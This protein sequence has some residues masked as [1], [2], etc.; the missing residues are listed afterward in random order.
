MFKKITSLNNDIVKNLIKLN[1]KKNISTFAL[2]ESEKVV[3]S[4][5]NKQIVETLFVEEKFLDQIKEYNITTYIIT[6]A[7]SKKISSLKSP[8][9]IFALVRIPTFKETNSNFLVLENLQ[10]PSNLGAIFRCALATNY[11]TIY[12]I[13]SVC[14]YLPKVT[15]GSMGYNFDLN[16]KEFKNLDEF[17]D[18]K[19]K[20]NLYLICG[21]LNG[22]NIFDYKVKTKPYG[23]VIG[24]EG[25]GISSTMQSACNDIVTIPMQNEVESLNAS[26]SASI[27]M[28]MLNN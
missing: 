20:N 10:D 3:M 7:V 6:E 1:D 15:R 25:N 14:P 18:F 17:L 16:I 19:N 27:L 21:D 24:N 13:D 2:C 8:S 9:G 28:Y 12:L 26:V 5:L 4:L 22:Q 11:K 23:I